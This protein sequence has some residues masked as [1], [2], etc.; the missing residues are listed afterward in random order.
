MTTAETCLNKFKLRL[1]TCK[2]ASKQSKNGAPYAVMSCA[3][4]TGRTSL[5]KRC[6]PADPDV[7]TC[8][9]CRRRTCLWRCSL[10]RCLVVPWRLLSCRAP[11]KP[12]RR[13]N[14]TLQWTIQIS[15]SGGGV[16]WACQF[17]C[18]IPNLT[19]VGENGAICFYRCC[20]RLTVL[21]RLQ[22]L[23]CD[24]HDA[25]ARP[26]KHFV[27]CVFVLQ[28]QLW[29]NLDGSFSPVYLAILPMAASKDAHK[30]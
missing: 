20:C 26:T 28:A 8:C 10:L 15:R 27:T 9:C 7:L 14:S 21:R 6:Q 11:W 3:F 1:S 4:R 18:S 5:F 2:Q 16:L 17:A 29:F 13:H 19:H 23:S 25:A 22:F 24:D 12:H 30:R